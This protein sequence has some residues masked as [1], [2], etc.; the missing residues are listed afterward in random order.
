MPRN[1]SGEYSLPYNWNTDKTDGIKVLAS[2][3]QAQDQDIAN[4]LTQSVSKD[5]Q[6][7]YTGDQDFNGNKCV[8]LGD[9][10]DAADSVNVS[11]VQTGEFQFFGVS[12]TTPAGTNGEDY[13]IGPSPTISVYPPYVRFSFLCHYTCIDNPNIRFGSLATKTLKKSNGASGYIALE[14]GDMIAD[15]EYVGVY[16]EDINSADIIIENPEIYPSLQ[17]GAVQNKTIASGQITVD[18]T[19]SNYN[20]DTEASAASD[21]L[22]TINGGVAGY[23]IVIKIANN[24]RK[25][26]IT[27]SGN[28]SLASGASYE[29]TNTISRLVLMYDAVLTKWVEISRTSYPFLYDS[30]V[31]TITNAGSLTLAHNLGKIPDLIVWQMKCVSAEHGYSVDDIVFANPMMGQAS[32]TICYGVS[33]VPDATNLN[34][35]MSDST[36]RIMNKSN[37]AAA[38]ITLSSWRY[39]FKCY[40]LSS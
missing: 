39:I 31:Q 28:V 25:V 6:T 10:E 27:T 17:A 4:A 36:P 34:I 16:N 3:M 35:R 32:S 22:D 18:P 13:D 11:Q 5:G 30:G 20:I 14:A 8:D 21:D 1:G 19:F 37:G 29:I 40:V 23:I 24:A 9:G 7:A 33:I 2:R 12:T 38:D 15:K 26:N